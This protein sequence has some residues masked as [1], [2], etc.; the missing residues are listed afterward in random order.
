M[1]DI[2]VAYNT[3]NDTNRVL[4][5]DSCPAN[6]SGKSGIVIANNVFERGSYAGKPIFP[7]PQNANNS[8]FTFSGNIFGGGS[9]LGD[10]P[11]AGFTESASLSVA[12]SAD[13]TA[14]VAISLPAELD[15]AGIDVAAEDRV[16]D[17]DAS[18]ACVGKPSTRCPCFRSR[19]C[20]PWNLER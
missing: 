3:L 17:C 14:H 1:R 19:P 15:W 6:V 5:C 16:I 20:G 4:L 18:A 2:V 12:G 10:V 8:A 7:P 13:T 9:E 11:I